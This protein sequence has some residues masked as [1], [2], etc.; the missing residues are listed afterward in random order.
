MF[1]TGRLAAP[2]SIAVAAVSLSL[3][4]LP[5]ASPAAA[6]DTV[7]CDGGDTLTGGV[8]TVASGET[9]TVSA[10]TSL[11]KLVITDATSAITVPDGYSLSIVVDGVE[12]GQAYDGANVTAPVLVPGTYGSSSGTGVQLVLTTTLPYTIFGTTFPLRQALAIDSSGVNAGRSVSQAVSGGSYDAD[13]ADG[14]TIASTGEGMA[15][16]DVE[17]G[18]YRITD[19]TIAFDGNGRL[20]FAGIGAGIRAANS[21]T[22][23]RVE[24]ADI[25]NTGAVRSGV[26]VTDGATGVIKDSTIVTHDGTLPSDYTLSPPPNMRAVPWALG[27]TG[28][29]RATNMVGNGTKATYLNDDVSSTN[30]GVLSTDSTSNSFLT[31]IGTK[32]TTLD[33]GYGSYADGSSVTDTFL[34]TTF[35]VDDYG[36][37]STGGTINL[38]DAST[39]AV[40]ALNVEHS[41]GL[42]AED[43]A[44]V[45]AGAT[46]IDSGRF[47]IMWH[48]GGS[49]N[50]AGGTVNIGGA[51][52]ITTGETTFQD[53]ASGVTLNLD[54]SAGATVKSGTGVIFQVMESDDPGGLSTTS[55][56]TDPVYGNPGATATRTTSWDLTDTSSS[57]K[58][59]VV[60]LTDIATTGDYYNA[61]YETVP[62]NLVL[63]LSGS[64]VT[65]LISSS[66]SVHDVGTITYAGDGYRH[67]G[68]VTNT[69]SAPVNNGVIVD[70][71]DAS[72]W[73]VTGTSYLTSLTVDATSTIVGQGGKTVSIT[74]GGTTYTAADLA[75]RTI[76]GTYGDPIVVSVP[77]SDAASTTTVAAD[78]TTYG[79][80]GSARV[81]VADAAGEPASGTV[82]VAVDGT[83][84]GSATLTGGAATV[85]LPAD[86][87]AG[88]HTVTATYAGDPGEALAGSTASTTYAV[89][90]VSS[91]ATLR[92][93]R[94]KVTRG[95]RVRATITVRAA[96]TPTGVVRVLKGAKVIASY[97]LSAARNGTLKVALPRLRKAGTYRLRVVYAGSTN[98]SGSRSAAVRLKVTRR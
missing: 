10:T 36:V 44:D 88:R 19:P 16:I 53:K 34:G 29:V 89:A 61:A 63:N 58:P 79:H 69:V 96:A 17:G 80:A 93:A 22:S 25:D 52:A 64:K 78:G 43:I 4:Q 3:A 51:T 1:R 76:T 14:V 83:T 85:A 6:D 39:A 81:S 65:G 12:T 54:G 9:C 13:G 74:Q 40:A 71:A 20:D 42:T 62:K 56:Y 60:N 7:S 70:L 45:V 55:T 2:L 77:D 90:R 31:S 95:T 8:L 94:H 97:S 72:T 91:S 41:L 87:D 21:G 67:I 33:G 82:T 5:A 73:K 47:G 28:N 98:V 46:T 84:V 23:V 24:G 32:V 66:T 37:I 18:E 15:G 11:Q 92:L 26:V 48:G 50:I 57:K 59:A 35:D 49:S 68:E 30:W 75:G 38:G 27:L 86:V